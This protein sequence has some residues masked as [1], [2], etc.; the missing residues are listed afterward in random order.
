M[1]ISQLTGLEHLSA[2]ITGD[3]PP[4]SIFD[5]MGMFNLEVS[6]G[7]VLLGCCAT[8]QHCNPMGGVHGGFAATVLDSVTGCAVHSMLEAGVSYG[9]VDLAVKMMK[10]VP[11]N[12]KLI[13][14]AKV[15]HISRSLGIAEGTIRNSEG[16]LLASGSATCFIKRPKT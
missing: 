2:I 8:E 13:A 16:K 4:P 10:P 1:N 7:S 6:Q 12:E 5:T 14:E 9:T 11:I 3:I 15:T